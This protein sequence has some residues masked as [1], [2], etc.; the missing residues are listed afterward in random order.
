[1][2]ASGPFEWPVCADGYE[3]R[4][5]VTDHAAGG[6]KFWHEELNW[7]LHPVSKRFSLHRPFVEWPDL[8]IRVSELAATGPTKDAI[9]AFAREYG[10]LS[11]ADVF[12]EQ[13]PE[14]RATEG[15]SLH[16]WHDDTFGLRRFRLIEH[17]WALRRPLTAEMYGSLNERLGSVIEPA[18]IFQVQRP[19]R[20]AAT[21]P[22]A[23]V[24]IPTSLI[25]AAYA[26]LVMA[27]TYAADYHLCEGCGRGL[28]IRPGF[29][30]QTRRHCDAACKKRAWRAKNSQAARTARRRNR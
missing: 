26:Q 19:P 21:T 1:M 28:V 25:G 22:P 5:P 10:Q 7:T 27:L 24:L 15:V 23:A 12:G 13:S 30:R 20:T 18:V 2:L 3:W 8:F 9:L 16:R 14:T 17:Q 29:E 11:T 6:I 4:P